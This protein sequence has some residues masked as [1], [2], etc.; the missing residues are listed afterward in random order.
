LRGFAL[1]NGNQK[2]QKEAATR[3][4]K[5]NGKKKRQKT[6]GSAGKRES[7]CYMSDLNNCAKMA[8]CRCLD[9]IEKE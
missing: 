7:D 2:R 8:V 5:R 1:Q 3:K 9:A 4:G 6:R